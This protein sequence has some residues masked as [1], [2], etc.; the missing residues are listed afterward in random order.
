CAAPGAGTP[1]QW[2]HLLAYNGG[3]I[4]SY[5]VAGTLAGAIGEAGLLTRAAPM[6][7]PLMYFLASLML[8]ALGLY[9]TG[10]AP[11]VARIEA[12]GAWIWRLV[13]PWT[14][15]M[16]PVTSVARAAGL[17]A[18]WGWLPCGMVYAVLLTAL[19]LGSWWQ[20]AALMLAFGLGTLP[21][22]LGIG[23]FYEKIERLR[24]AGAARVLAGTA[25]A[26]FGLFGIAKAW[27]PAAM[28]G[29]GLL[30]YMIPG[31]ETWFQ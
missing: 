11:V 27:H 13:Q 30:C 4:F 26:A 14:G 3:R 31:L 21:N 1:P 12:A 29:G 5:A 8:T 15:R 19:A 18:L 10:L 23:L 6:L 24:R 2:P 28:A 17:G 7:Q 16:L 9:L 25:I 20:G 22:M